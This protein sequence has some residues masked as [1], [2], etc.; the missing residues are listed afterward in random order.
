MSGQID[1]A[2]FTPEEIGQL[3]AVATFYVGAFKEDE[4]MTLFEKLRLQEIEQI[5]ERHGYRY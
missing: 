1:P 5:L 2:N 3:L 4:K